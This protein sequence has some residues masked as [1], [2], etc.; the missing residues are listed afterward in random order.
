MVKVNQ[1]VVEQLAPFINDRRKSKIEAVITNRLQS[2]QLAIEAPSDINNALAAIRTAEALGISE[3][4]LIEVEGSVHGIRAI[5]QG[6]FYW[7]NIRIHA[8]RQ[9]FFDLI[10][11]SSIQLAGGALNLTEPLPLS[12]V[13][14]EH[15]VCVVVGNEHHGLS[16][17]MKEA[18]DFLYQIPMVGMSESLNLSV[19]AAISLYDITSRRRALLKQSGDLSS[20]AEIFL[21]AKYY[22]KSVSK[23]LLETVLKEKQ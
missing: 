18:C 5:T 14:I 13:P 21:R 8:A 7:V 20:D 16:L 12:S 11:Q 15:P 6:A 10:K 22:K 9:D 1:T 17:A 4:H 19:S 2:I 3:V 23:R